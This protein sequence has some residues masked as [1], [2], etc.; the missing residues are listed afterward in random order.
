MEHDE[1]SCNRAGLA[2]LRPASRVFAEPAPPS[3]AA[4]RTA[5]GRRRVA[6]RQLRGLGGP[7]NRA[8]RFASASPWSP[9]MPLDAGF[10]RE[11]L[12]RHPPAPRG[13]GARWAGRAVACLQRR[14]RP[15]RL[16][17]RCRS[18]ARRSSPPSGYIMP[19]HDRR[20]ARRANWRRRN[21]RHGAWC[22]PARRTGV[23][24]PARVVP[25]SRSSSRRTAYPRCTP[26]D[27]RPGS[28][29]IA[30][31]NR[32]AVAKLA[33]GRA[34]S[35]PSATPAGST[36]ARGGRWFSRRCLGT[37]VALLRQRLAQRPR[38]HDLRKGDV[39]SIG[40]PRLF[41]PTSFDLA[42]GSAQVAR[43]RHAIEK[44]AAIAACRRSPQPAERDVSPPSAVVWPTTM[45][46]LEDLLGQL[47]AS[48]RRAI[49]IPAR[50]TA[51]DHP[52][53]TCLNRII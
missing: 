38:R 3:R 19:R 8:A 46:M 39:L 43:A 48:E 22:R 42:A 23:G 45:E 32:R 33:S 13:A 1:S 24:R 41:R 49:R 47:A 11:K 26:R 4:W 35:T 37:G 14:R 51:A 30:R 7:Y 29:S 50:R 15:V 27:R 28:I 36:H 21:L 6:H 2:S 17:R 5:T 44:S 52:A 18:L 16:H 25:T 20:S 12:S 31:D 10:F 53:V 40:S 9:E 34:C